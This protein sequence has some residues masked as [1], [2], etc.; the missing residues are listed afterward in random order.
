MA[1]S[2]SEDTPSLQSRQ[3]RS[4][5]KLDQLDRVA[6][7]LAASTLTASTC[8]VNDVT[9]L[10]TTETSIGKTILSKY[11]PAKLQGLYGLMRTT[12]R[13]HIVDDLRK[14]V[15]A[16]QQKS[17]KWREV[18]AMAAA[19]RDDIAESATQGAW[20]KLEN[21]CQ[22]ALENTQLLQ[23]RLLWCKR[24]VEMGK[25][26]LAAAAERRVWDEGAKIGSQGDEERG[27]SMGRD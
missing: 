26:T 14:D 17:R 21:A 19:E 18:M 7:W 4:P 9:E 22:R 20:E 11:D 3:P 2:P 13:I 10:I 6:E 25:L 16:R 23:E 12:E 5:A 8:P 27:R 1:E 24:N 15:H